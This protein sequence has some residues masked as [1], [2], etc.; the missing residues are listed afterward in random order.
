MSSSNDIPIR[1][2]RGT[3]HGEIVVENEKY[4]LW[5]NIYGEVKVLDGGKMYVRGNI[6]GS[7]FVDFG[8][9]VHI[10]GKVDGNLTLMRGTKVINSGLV[11]G[12]A[13]NL[14]GRLYVDQHGSI[15]GKV[16]TEKNGET[17]I[18]SKVD[19]PGAD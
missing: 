11:T 2:E 4:T 5:G 14:G 10:F 19:M 7:L 8:G 13:S 12:T 15:L 1:E 6:F 16:K 9:R 3:I 17:V 18:E